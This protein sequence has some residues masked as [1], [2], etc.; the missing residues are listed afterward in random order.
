VSSLPPEV[1]VPLPLGLACIELPVVGDVPGLAELAAGSP[2]VE[3]RPLGAPLWA[4]AKI[5]KSASAPATAIVVS[6]MVIPFGL[7]MTIRWA[8]PG[9]AGTSWA[10]YRVAKAQLYRT[11]TFIELPLM[12]GFHRMQQEVT[13]F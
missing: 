2:V 5:L 12:V 4:Y 3:P 11:P 8:Q 10:R 6:L 7:V 13:L 9:S 1:E